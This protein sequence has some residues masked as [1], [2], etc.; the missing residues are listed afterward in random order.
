M[1]ETTDPLASLSA[2]DIPTRA[3]G[4]RDLA[5]TGGPEHL[6]LLVSM[7]LAD[8]SPGVRLGAAAAAA[9]ILSRVRVGSAADALTAEQRTSLWLKIK[10]VDPGN[11]AGIFQVCATLGV[12]DASS[13]IFGAMR[14]PRADVRQGAC[15]GLSRLCA[16]AA[17]NG[18]T[19]LE[20]RVVALFDD[21][22]VRPDT[23]AEIARVCAVVGY[24]TALPAV[25]RLAE[26]S[27]RGVATIAL[28]A[29]QRLEF[30]PS[31][32]GVWV[33]LGVDAGE[34]DA[35]AEVGA[36][37]AVPGTEA[38]VRIQGEKATLE[39]FPAAA[40]LLWAKR[41]GATEATV[42]LQVGETTFWSAEGEELAELADRLVAAE[43]YPLVPLLDGLL[44][45][46]ASSARLRGVAMQRLGD[47]EGAIEHLTAAL[48]MKRVPTDT[49]WYLADALLAAGRAEEA[50]P[51]LERYLGKASKKAPFVAE[52]R[53]R[54]GLE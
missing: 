26:S 25:R 13:R 17:V 20:A 52:A 3:A 49:S 12:P 21:A 8:P 11:N 24:R 45:V 43:A 28:E 40:R 53:R 14:D 39:A 54:L 5:A 6:P 27:L 22:R 33:D 32:V 29:Q 38:L 2:R 18:D 35:G 31:V 41:P 42:A 50:R 46:S 34:V 51:H 10:T 36:M 9:D 48:E 47:L 23:L 15:V 30:P 4:A 19:G 16:S 37:L 7:A 44:P 1:S